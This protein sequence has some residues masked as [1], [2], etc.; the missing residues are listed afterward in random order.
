MNAERL[1]RALVA[2]TVGA[3]MS[4][5]AAAPPPAKDVPVTSIVLDYAADIAPAL[6]IRSDGAGSYL[7]SKALT[8]L[9][10]VIGDWVLDSI[11]QRNTTRR[12]YLDLSQAVPGSGS[13]ANLIPAGSYAFRALAQ[14]STYGNSLL[15]FTAGQVKT[16]P[17]RIGF[18]VGTTRYAIVMNPTGGVHGPFPETDAATATC[19][20][21]PTG[22][23][24]CSRWK[25]TPSGTYIAP[26]G[27]VKYRNVSRLLEFDSRGNVVADHGDFYMSFAIVM[28]K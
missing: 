5:M 12:I 15:G 24:P 19:I 16:C 3:S 14:C 22:S 23:A 1:R 6:T 18:D 21:P 17:L 27:S 11:N 20:D 8:S 4:S 25:L 13:L 28:E 9:I 10:Q 2:L 7:N 26:D